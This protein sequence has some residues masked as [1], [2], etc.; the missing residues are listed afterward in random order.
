MAINAGYF[1][2]E[3][4]FEQRFFENIDLLAD[5]VERLKSMNF[6]VVLTS[7]SFDMLHIGHARYLREAKKLG[8]V[9]IVGIESDEKVRS[10]KKGSMRPVVPLTER[11]EML[12]HLRYVDIITVKGLDDAKWSLIKRLRPNVLQAVE[13]TYKPEDIPELKQYCDELIIQPRQAETSTSAKIRLLVIEGMRN[14]HAHFTAHL[15]EWITKYYSEKV[16][17]MNEDFRKE[18]PVFLDE[19]L[20]EL[21]EKDI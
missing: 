17:A 1:G 10:R 15:P 18:L 6:K 7:G 13:G 12:A 20:L 19:T 11:T 2:D 4:N 21:Q 5:E 14:L 16:A 3:F 8:D 9:L